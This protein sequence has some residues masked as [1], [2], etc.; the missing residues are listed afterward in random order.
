MNPRDFLQ[1]SGFLAR[2]GFRPGICGY[3]LLLSHM[4][5]RSS[6]LSH[7]IGSNPDVIGYFENHTKLRNGFELLSLTQKVAQLTG[8]S[9][10]GKWIYDKILHSNLTVSPEVLNRPDVLP[11]FLVREPRESIASI[12]KQLAD[13][14]WSEKK[15]AKYYTRRVEE[16][17]NL[18]SQCDGEKLVLDSGDLVTD[19]EEALAALTRFVGVATPFTSRY[20][21]GDL[22]GVR[23]FGDSSE[24]IQRGE[25]VKTSLEVDETDSNNDAFP[26]ATAAYE[27]F[28]EQ[29]SAAR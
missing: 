19:T 6:V 14:G 26:D 10:R 24:N 23:K 1:A 13:K 7:V 12:R 20:E 27:T 28:R 17:T 11:L 15:A 18:I 3:I 4:R 29:G 8:E 9:P 2:S 21:K 22:T 16:L 25:I 5:S